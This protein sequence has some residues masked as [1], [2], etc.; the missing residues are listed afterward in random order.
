MSFGAGGDSALGVGCAAS[1]TAF[2][3]AEAGAA[4]AG[5]AAGGGGDAATSGPLK[6]PANDASSAAI[7]QKRRGTFGTL[8]PC[9]GFSAE[10]RPERSCLALTTGTEERLQ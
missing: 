3:T 1:A 4:A 8:H 7:A 2:G 10:R 6:I 9:L 5:N